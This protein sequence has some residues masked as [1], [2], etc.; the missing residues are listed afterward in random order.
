MKTGVKTQSLKAFEIEIEATNF[1]KLIANGQYERKDFDVNEDN[2]PIKNKTKRTAFIKLFKF[3]RDIFYRKDVI[4]EMKKEDFRPAMIEELLALG[5]SHKELQ[6]TSPI[7][8][9]GA[10]WICQHSL[11]P[12]L[13]MENFGKRKVREITTS[14]QIG[15]WSEYFSFAGVH[16]IS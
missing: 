2:F 10:V 14:G 9:L 7:V 3:D 1:Q 16:E 11:F 4:E 8:A 6:K 15:Y 5:A 12:T 13:K